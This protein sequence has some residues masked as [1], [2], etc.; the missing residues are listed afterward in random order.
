VGSS[1]NLINDLDLS[2]TNSTFLWSPLVTNADEFGRSYDLKNNLEFISLP[3]ESLKPNT[4]YTVTVRARSLS[5]PQP[6]SLVLSGEIGYFIY[7][8]AT[9][10]VSSGLSH[11]AR[12]LVIVAC[13]LTCCLT[14]LVLYVGF[15]NP[16]R[17]E[18][19]NNAKEILRILEN[20]WY[21]RDEDYD[22]DEDAEGGGVDG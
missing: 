14:S 9:S 2:V 7:H 15:V 21:D 4:N 5:R 16:A 8:D 22:S 18:R 6:Y 17:R 3:M 19:I 11:T 10:G 1:K 20:V 12:V 13:C